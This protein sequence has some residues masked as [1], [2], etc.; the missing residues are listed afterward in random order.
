MKKEEKANY[1]ITNLQ[2]LFDTLKSNRSLIFS[3]YYCL[4]N[5]RCSKKEKEK[6]TST[7]E[8]SIILSS[9]RS[10]ISQWTLR[11]F[12][13]YR[14]SYFKRRLTEPFE[15]K[16]TRETRN[17]ENSVAFIAARFIRRRRCSAKSL[18]PTRRMLRDYDFGRRSVKRSGLHPVKFGRRGQRNECRSPQN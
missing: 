1:K 6:I 15:K 18:E 9:I 12:S 11:V 2:F 3:T 8:R 16:K 10:R 7:F 14:L 5:L 13:T 17:R 4:R